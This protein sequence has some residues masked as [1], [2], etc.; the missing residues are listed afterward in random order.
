MTKKCLKK[1]I[2]AH[3]ILTMIKNAFP[4]ETKN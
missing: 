1:W 3:V 4:N 2:K